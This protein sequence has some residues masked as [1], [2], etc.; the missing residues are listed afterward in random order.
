MI[1]PNKTAIV[2]GATGLI[3]SAIVAQLERTDAFNSIVTLTRRPVAFNGNKVVNHVVDF[4]RLGDFSSLFK[5]DVLFSCLGTTLK[6]AGSIEAQRSVDLDYQ[7]QAAEIACE[8]GVAHYLLVSSSGANAKSVS[9]YLK[10]KGEL[11]Q[12]IKALPFPRI[13]IFQPS[14]LLGER[15]DTR[16]GEALA[17][18]LLPLICRLPGLRRYRPIRGTQV[19]HKMVSESLQAGAGT[20]TFKLEQVFPA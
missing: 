4:D 6:Q 12:A 10:M 1:E 3:G 5:G 19:A 2:I 9:P 7:L 14:L 8:Q 17:S 18:K 11:E 13:S 15:Q 16:A 20:Y